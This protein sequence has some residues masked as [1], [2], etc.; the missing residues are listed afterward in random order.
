VK[1]LGHRQ[2]LPVPFRQRGTVLKGTA[3]RPVAQRL[4]PP[5]DGASPSRD[6]LHDTGPAGCDP[7]RR[8]GPA[9]SQPGA[10]RAYRGARRS[11]AAPRAAPP[12]RRR[13]GPA[14]SSSPT[15]RQLRSRTDGSAPPEGAGD[16]QPAAEVRRGRRA[17]ETVAEPR[18]LAAG[19][20]RPCHAAP[21]RLS[22]SPSLRAWRGL[23]GSVMKLGRPAQVPALQLAICNLYNSM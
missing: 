1:G 7:S 13:G 4:L 14:V 19:Y 9:R 18:A 22:R 8:A 5:A 21:G 20:S 23:L 3:R 12:W 11:S 17:E 10:A 6:G 15:W 16:R 2:C